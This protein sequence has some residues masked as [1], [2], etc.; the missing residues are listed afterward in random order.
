L[1]GPKKEDG[2]QAGV[3]KEG[4]VSTRKRSAQIKSKTGGE[5]K[6]CDTNC[7]KK[8]RSIKP[9]VREKLGKNWEHD[10]GV[11]GK[12]VGR[13]SCVWKNPLFVVAPHKTKNP[14]KNLGIEQKPLTIPQGKDRSKRLNTSG[15]VPKNHENSWLKASREGETSC[16][17][18]TRW[19][20][21]ENKTNRCQKAPK[22]PKKQKKVTT[23]SLIKSEFK[24]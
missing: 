23:K 14:Q 1:R 10:G 22:N 5:K 18:P 21:P 4:G 24:V 8:K 15:K 6:V 7:Q 11:R 12:I 13:K 2:R 19:S 20:H 9:L 3:C 17:G 16:W